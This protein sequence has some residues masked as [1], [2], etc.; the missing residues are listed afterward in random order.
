VVRDGANDYQVIDTETINLIQNIPNYGDDGSLNPSVN[1]RQ[2][3]GILVTGTATNLVIYV[4]SSDPRIGAGPG[5]NDLGL[6]TNSGIISR[7]TWNGSSW[8]KVDLVRG[9]PRSE[10]NH[11]TN[12]MQL[13]E[14]NNILYVA[15]GGHTNAGAPSN[16]FAFSTEYALS[17]AIL[18]IDLDAIEAL[19]LPYDL[20]TLNDPTRPGNPDANDPFG[21]NDGLNQAKLIDGGPVQVYAGGFR[22]PYDLVITQASEMYT[23]DNGP[24]GGWGGWPD[25]EGP[26][27]NCTNDY[28][29]GEPGFV[30][31]QDNLHRID[32]PG[33]YAGHPAPIRGNIA[34]GLGFY[35]NA[36]GLFVFDPNPTAD[37]P[38]VPPSLIDPI[39]CDFQQP[40]VDDD[41]LVT[42]DASTNG[43][44]EY[45]AGN[46]S[47]ALQGNLLAAGFD[48]T[49][50]RI[51]L[52]PAS[53]S[54][55]TETLAANFGNLPLD[56]TAQGDSVDDPFP[57]TLWVAVYGTGKISVFEP[58]DF[59]GGGPT[60]CTGD[61]DPNLDEDSDGYN[62]ADEIDNGTNPC[63]SASKPPDVDGDFVSDL[64]DT[65]DDND[66]V[67]DTEDAFVLDS[68][69]GAITSIPLRYDLFNCCP[70]TGFFGVGFTGLMVNGDDYLNLFDQSDLVV[71][72]T[73][74]LFT[75]PNVGT[76]TAL[77]SANTQRN[78]LQFGVNADSTTGPYT[79]GT[80]VVATFFNNDPQANQSQGLY[81]GNGD[82]DNYL[83]ISLSANDGNGGIKVLQEVGGT[84]V[85]DTLFDA[86]NTPSLSGLLDATSIQLFLQVDPALGTVQAQYSTNGGTVTDLGSPITLS[87]DVLNSVQSSSSP[88]AIGVIATAG[89]GPNFTATWDW[90][91]VKLPGSPATEIRVNAGGGSY[92]DIAGNAWDADVGFNTGKTFSTTSA[93]ANTGDDIL[94]QSERWDPDGGN[95]LQYAFAVAD[96]DY[97][98]NLYLAE[99][100]PGTFSTGARVFDVLA[101]GQLVLDD[102]DIFSEAG[103]ETA[104]VKSIPVTVSDGQLNIE[105]LHQVQNPKISAIEILSQ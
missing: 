72:G 58:D 55:S 80:S 13:D 1:T 59:D 8:E 16:N 34:A 19:G 82:Q 56:I 105:F 99:I 4:S 77:G 87:G 97:T 100:Y 49:I 94:Y 17:G 70:G 40:G 101:E 65:D 36:S 39:E 15:Q 78:A 60:D 38:P 12:G 71:G 92:T 3:T 6:D 102:V 84:V 30:N 81:I 29:D 75:D 95:E 25:N 41:A 61:D 98:V 76:G 20:P 57:G 9:L 79:V 89:S 27:G 46:F 14:V 32:G 2:I 64:N 93:I 28:V 51:I 91:E 104:L 45:T 67:I 74:G 96:G 43:L 63:S 22:N 53:G 50:Q 62:N 42:W 26:A 47:G 10:E 85:D 66:G 69:N 48:N 54:A 88:L 68:Q 5:S 86:T 7:L 103:A 52:D 11:A 18:S 21:G 90:V 24:N 35:D 23:I 83:E 73:A 33:D 31:N 44:T 37:W